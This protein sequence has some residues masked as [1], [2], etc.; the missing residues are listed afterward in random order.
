VRE[1]ALM[2]FSRCILPSKNLPLDVPGIELVGVASLEGVDDRRN[3][4]RD[5]N[6]GG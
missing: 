5:R 4:H 1:A 3:Q 6:S 2:G